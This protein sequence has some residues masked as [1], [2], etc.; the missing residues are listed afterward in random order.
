MCSKPEVSIIKG[1][2]RNYPTERLHRIFEEN[3]TS[4]NCGNKPAIIFND[5]EFTYKHLNQSANRI[6]AALIKQFDASKLKP[7]EDGDWIIAVCMP[8]SDEL[9]IALLAILK[10]GAAYLPIDITFPKSRIDHILQEAK[11]SFII[12]DNT[13]VGRSLFGDTIAASFD[14][15]KRLSSEYDHTN[16]SDD[17][18][19]Q[20]TSENTPALVLYTS[21]STEVPK[22]KRIDIPMYVSI[23]LIYFQLLSIQGV[24]LS[25]A[26]IMN[27]LQWQWDLFPYS[28]TEQVCVFKTALTFVD[29]I[30]E[31]WSPLLSSNYLA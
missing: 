24:R 7:N 31:I 8:P 22:G 20:P 1:L 23:S 21:G 9:I 30:S 26:V 28:P 16:I 18:M 17:R 11:P 6:A 4:S 29:S 13:A 19:L 12:Y 10:T 27:R 5:R 25:H 14:E 2:N 3:L 15:C